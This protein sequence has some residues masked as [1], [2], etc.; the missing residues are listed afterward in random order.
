MIAV[1]NS[2]LKILEFQQP[3]LE[4]W[5]RTILLAFRHA[6]C[7]LY[8]QFRHFHFALGTINYVAMVCCQVYAGISTAEPGQSGNF[9][10]QDQPGLS[11][12]P[13]RKPSFCRGARRTFLDHSCKPCLE[14]PRQ[15]MNPKSAS[16]AQSLELRTHSFMDPDAWVHLQALPLTVCPWDN[17]LTSLCLGFH[18]CDHQERTYLPHELWEQNEMIHIQSL[19]RS[20]DPGRSVVDSRVVFLSR[21]L[22]LKH[23]I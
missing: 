7:C 12:L 11:C 18:I 16:I 8:Q 20:K 13:L 23:L 9:T 15:K 1:F 21:L 19:T 6:L 22:F 17:Y 2:Q 10:S 14:P 5:C 4:C 3:A